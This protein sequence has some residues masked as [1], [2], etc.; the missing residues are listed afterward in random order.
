MLFDPELTTTFRSVCNQVLF[1]PSTFPYP[2]QQTL[3]RI[4][5]LDSVRSRHCPVFSLVEHDTDIGTP[6]ERTQLC[7]NRNNRQRFLCASLTN[8][9]PLTS[10]LAMKDQREG[11]HERVTCGIMTDEA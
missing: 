8:A 11:L 5:Q 10:A 7:S 1:L 9:L 6:S 4:N 3:L 2:Y